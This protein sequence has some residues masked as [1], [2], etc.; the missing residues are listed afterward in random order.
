MG[1]GCT[2]P[3]P[4]HSSPQTLA[5]RQAPSTERATLAV[6][7]G[8]RRRAA[9]CAGWTSSGPNSSDSAAAAPAKSSASSRQV[10]STCRLASSCTPAAAASAKSVST[11][12]G[13]DAHT[14]IA[15][16][17]AFGPSAKAVPSSRSRRSSSRAQLQPSGSPRDDIAS[18]WSNRFRAATTRRR[19]D[20]VE[21][22]SGRG[23]EASGG[24]MRGEQQLASVSSRRA[25]EASIYSVVAP[26]HGV[27][28]QGGGG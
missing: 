22:A 8:T 27:C 5:S 1:L 28:Q 17:C 9:P 21:S 13:D 23:A 12:P 3:A 19:S 25:E 2:R 15:R 18:S 4:L 24:W 16:L 6:R 20:A 14:R 7:A 10:A 26:T 11:V